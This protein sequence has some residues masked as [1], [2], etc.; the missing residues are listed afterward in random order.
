MDSIK[1]Q[2]NERLKH[3]CSKNQCEIVIISHN[4]K[5]TLQ[6]VDLTVSNAAKI[7]IQNHYNVWF[8]NQVGR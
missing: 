1:R 4:L 7:F 2:D 3:N 5:N 6:S 8:S